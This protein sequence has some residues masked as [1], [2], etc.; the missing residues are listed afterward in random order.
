[1]EL[2]NENDIPKNKPYKSIQN[3]E[4]LL[5]VLAGYQIQ[6][7]VYMV[8]ILKIQQKIMDKVT[9]KLWINLFRRA[10]IRIASRIAEKIAAPA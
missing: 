1:M 6:C 3:V 4:D 7:S 9:Y 8:P 2:R 5:M 10:M